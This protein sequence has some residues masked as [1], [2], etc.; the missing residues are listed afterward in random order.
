MIARFELPPLEDGSN[1][2]TI[3][4]RG[5]LVSIVAIGRSEIERDATTSDDRP[6]TFDR[7]RT[8]T[9]LQSGSERRKSDSVNVVRLFGEKIG[10][11]V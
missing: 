9:R 3:T 11:N 1:D 8:K 7:R 4:L 2:L 10:K 5:R 6:D